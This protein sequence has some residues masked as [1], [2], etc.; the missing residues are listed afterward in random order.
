MPLICLE[1]IVLL[2]LLSIGIWRK[3]CVFLKALNKIALAGKS[4]AV[5]DLGNGTVW[6]AEQK[7]TG[8][9][10]AE[11]GSK[12]IEG[13][14]RNSV[15]IPVDLGDADVEGICDLL[16][17]QWLVK[18]ADQ[19]LYHVKNIA[20]GGVVSDHASRFGQAVGFIQK[21]KKQKQILFGAGLLKA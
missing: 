1:M 21:N 14:S 13:L 19:I 11:I 20:V 2:L 17:G 9:G 6:M 18:M 10:Q 12:A 5:C 8:A 16:G 15:K 3:P 7:F 4:A